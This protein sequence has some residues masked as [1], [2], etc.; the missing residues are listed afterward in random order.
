MKIFRYIN[1]Y[2]IIKSNSDYRGNIMAINNIKNGKLLYHLTRLDNLESI[3]TNGLVSRSLVRKNSINFG[4]VAD[5]RIIVKRVKLGLDEYVPFHFHPYSAFDKV[6]KSTYINDEFVYITITRECA[7]SN[8]FK[9]L[10]RHPLAN[11]GYTLLEYDEGFKA[12]DWKAMETLGNEDEHIKNV[13]MAE[14]LTNLRV[15]ANC[16]Q[17]ICVRNEE[18]KEQVEEMLENNG[19]LEHP[20][21]VNIQNWFD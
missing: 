7:R 19:I 10:P 6:V 4:N 14:C 13:K 2:V 5:P 15:P 16:F 21:Y 20:P 11:E 12:I 18:I 3:I 8:K 17:S 1:K 9:I